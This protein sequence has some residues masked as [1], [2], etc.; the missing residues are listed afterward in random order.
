MAGQVKADNEYEGRVRTDMYCTECSKNF[1]ATL[2]FDLD[3]NHS[4]ICP[5]C[6]HEHQRVI[7]KGK[8]TSDR[9][10]SVHGTPFKAQTQKLWRSDNL[11]AQTSSASEFLREKWLNFGG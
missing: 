2:D 5:H 6:G 7:K 9:W 1:L 8:V 10:G 11:K 4:I 3:G